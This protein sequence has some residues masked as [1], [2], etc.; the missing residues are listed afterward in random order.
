MGASPPAVRERWQEDRD[1]PELIQHPWRACPF[2]GGGKLVPR[3]EEA[4]RRGWCRRVQAWRA[5]GGKVDLIPCSIPP[6]DVT[7]R[8][9]GLSRMVHKRA[10]EARGEEKL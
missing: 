4:P 1:R 6:N 10:W 7:K 2:V 8:A 3:N 5:A 9:R